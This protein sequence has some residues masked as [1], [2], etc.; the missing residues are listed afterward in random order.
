M[1]EAHRLIRSGR[2]AAMSAIGLMLMACGGGGGGGGSFVGSTP[3]PPPAPPAPPPP[4]SFTISAPARATTGAGPASVFAAAGGPNF[5]TG[6]ATGTALPIL[7]TVVAWDV[8]GIQADAAANAAG[9]TVRVEG[10][11]F[12]IDLPTWLATLDLVPSGHA[13]LDWTRVG[14][15]GVDDEWSGFGTNRAAFVF[16]YETPTAA[17]PSNGSATYS[18]QAEG[19][20]FNPV[21]QGAN[22]VHLSGNAT[23]T[24]DFGARTLAGSLTGMTANGAPWNDVAFNSAILGNGFSG[25]TSV[26]NSPAGPASLAGNATGTLEGRFFGPSAQEAGGVWTLFDGTSAAIGTLSGSNSGD[27]CLGCWDY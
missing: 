25:R 5:T 21:N 18:G 6:P 17:V 14:Y 4:A 12:A 23:F 13:N 20:V 27:P 16:G 19:S 22:E 9:A 24:A 8:D 7:Q 26:T 1:S 10:N 15:W 2:L 3:P 11:Q